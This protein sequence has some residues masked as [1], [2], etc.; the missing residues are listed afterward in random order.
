MKQVICA[1]SSRNKS[2]NLLVHTDINTLALKIPTDSRRLYRQPSRR[3]SKTDRKTPT[4][5]FNQLIKVNKVTQ[6]N[7]LR[8]L[9]II[10]TKATLFA[11]LRLVFI[12]LV[13]FLMTV[14]IQMYIQDLGWKM[15]MS[16]LKSVLNLTHPGGNRLSESSGR[17]WT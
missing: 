10:L 11:K 1:V 13:M 14:H 12:G 16:E 7:I 5:L 4:C 15:F 2:V 9:L 3:N 6:R 17:I 8:S